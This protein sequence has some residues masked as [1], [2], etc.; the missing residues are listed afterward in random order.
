[1]E[2]ASADEVQQYLDEYGARC[3]EVEQAE[4]VYRANREQAKV[5]WRAREERSG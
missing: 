5:W 3:K 1:M 2:R 4:Q